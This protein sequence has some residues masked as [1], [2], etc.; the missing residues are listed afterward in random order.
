MCHRNKNLSEPLNTAIRE[1]VKIYLSNPGT[2]Y[3]FVTCVTP[4]KGSRTHKLWQIVHLLTEEQGD[5]ADL[6]G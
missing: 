3:E 1:L 5:E 6:P 4:K 2:Q